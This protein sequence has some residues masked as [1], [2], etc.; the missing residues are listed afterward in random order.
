MES[1]I[2]YHRKIS[3]RFDLASLTET[4]MGSHAVVGNR[5]SHRDLNA[6]VI[7]RLHN[8]IGEV[9]FDRGQ[10]TGLFGSEARFL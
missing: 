6:W 4:G 2:N 3:T 5:W 10:L 7:C 1:T 9:S 8:S